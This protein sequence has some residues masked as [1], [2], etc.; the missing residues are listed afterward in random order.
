MARRKVSTFARLTGCRFNRK[1]RRKLQRQLCSP[2]PGLTHTYGQ[3][4]VDQGAARFEQ[5]QER[6]ELARLTA[7]AAA[8]GLKLVPL[9]AELK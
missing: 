4:W 8:R 7:R 1:E 6:S 5:I 2:D 3:A 9:V